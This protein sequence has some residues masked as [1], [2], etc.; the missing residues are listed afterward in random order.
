L[1]RALNLAWAVL[2]AGFCTLLQAA[3]GSAVGAILM[4]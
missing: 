1:E 4:L 3:S 2:P